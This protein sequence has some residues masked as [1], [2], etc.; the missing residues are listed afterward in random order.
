[1]ISSGHTW[2]FNKL[3]TDPRIQVYRHYVGGSQ[4]YF[5]GQFQ[6]TN[7][8]LQNSRKGVVLPIRTLVE[9]R[10]VLPHNRTP[11]KEHLIG[12]FKWNVKTEL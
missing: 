8:S 3:P 1:M 12:S 7:N 2:L 9:L 10:N 6:M 5:K 4:L 11:T